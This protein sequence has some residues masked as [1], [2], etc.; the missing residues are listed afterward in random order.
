L[1]RQPT[2]QGV[3]EKSVGAVA[4]TSGTVRLTTA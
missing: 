3:A 1:V 4:S 2:R